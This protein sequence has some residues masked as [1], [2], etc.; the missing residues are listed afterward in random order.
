V[1]ALVADINA[2][3][4]AL[5]FIPTPSAGYVRMKRALDVIIALTALILLAPLLVAIAF[6][7]YLDSGRPVFFRQ[8]RVGY[9]GHPFVIV[10][11]RSMR[12]DADETV[13]QRYVES[14]FASAAPASVFK[15]S[16][17]TRV[18]RLGAFLRRA[19]L[20]ELPQLWNVLCGDMSLVGPR[21]DVPYSVAEY[22]PW[23]RARL[24]ATP[25]ITGLWQVRGRSALSPDEM[26]RLDLDYVARRSLLLDLQILMRTVPAVLA[27]R[28]AA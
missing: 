19:S 23:M 6:A 2:F 4:P 26:F 25:G 5:E 12:K 8:K 13:H 1:N 17:D 16:H 28:G 20:D 22:A 27:A 7:V 10:K 14:L 15:I 3:S 11:F 18:T 9:R 21:P 24:A